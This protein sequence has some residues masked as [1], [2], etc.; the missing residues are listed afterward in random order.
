MTSVRGLCDEPQN[1]KLFAI[2]LVSLIGAPGEIDNIDKNTDQS[3]IK[4]PWIIPA[5]I[6]LNSKSYR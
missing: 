6:K 3:I 4:M 5:N 1:W 2:P